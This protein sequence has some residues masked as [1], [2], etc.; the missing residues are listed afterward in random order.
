QQLH[1]PIGGQLPLT[2]GETW[3]WAIG[4]DCSPSKRDGAQSTTDRFG[5]NIFSLNPTDDPTP[6][7]DRARLDGKALEGLRRLEDLAQN[8]PPETELPSRVPLSEIEQL[9]VFY[10][11]ECLDERLIAVLA[12]VLD[13]GGDL[14]A[15]TVL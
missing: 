7:T 10:S 12:K 6:Q 13:A 5:M 14:P 1:P 15:V 2:L 9:P 4:Q 11:R 8:T 3:S